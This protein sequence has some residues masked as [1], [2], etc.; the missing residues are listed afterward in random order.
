MRSGVVVH[1]M[2]SVPIS[3]AT[4]SVEVSSHGYPLPLYT[5]TIGS[6]AYCVLYSPI[7][8]DLCCLHVSC[9]E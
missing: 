8:S 1:G 2:R 7:V 5:H 6:T 4:M 3:F 9:A